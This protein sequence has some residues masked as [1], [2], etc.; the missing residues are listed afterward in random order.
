[1]IIHQLVLA[2]IEHPPSIGEDLHLTECQQI[3]DNNQ[4][5]ESVP[6]KKQVPV[7]SGAGQCNPWRRSM[8]SVVQVDAISGA[9]QCYQWCRPMLSVAQVVAISGAGEVFR[10]GP[11]PRKWFLCA[12][13]AQVTRH[14]P[15]LRHGH[16][17]PAPRTPHTCANKSHLR[18]AMKVNRTK[19]HG[20]C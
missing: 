10:W 17:I 5:P 19:R 1:M 18:H 6:P 7:V 3:T 14:F 4:K 9:G 20:R 2:K 11:A 12:V 8:L 16:P 15:H 13:M